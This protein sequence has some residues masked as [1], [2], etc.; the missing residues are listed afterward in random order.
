MNKKTL[1]TICFLFIIIT[2]S[3]IGYYTYKSYTDKKESSDMDTQINNFYDVEYLFNSGYILVPKTI[4][5]FSSKDGEIYIYLDANNTMYIKYTDKVEKN[6][7]ITGL[8][9]GDLTI[10]YNNIKDRYYEFVARTKDNDIYYVYTNINDSKDNKFTLIKDK[11]EK[12][13]IPAHDKKQVYINSTSKFITNYIFLGTDGELKYI[14]Y[15]IRYVFKDNLKD[16]KPYFD[17]ICASSNSIICNYLLAYITFNN[18]LVYDDEKLSDDQ[19]NIIYVNDV[20]ATFEFNSNK[21]INIKNKND[22]K[23]YNYSFI[24]YII[25]DKKDLYEFTITNKSKDL[26]KLTND[27]NKVKEYIYEKDIY[28]LTIVYEDTTT[29]V[30]ESNS[31]KEIITSTIYDKNSNNNEKVLIQP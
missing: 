15:N 11:I 24:L 22:L 29:K 12:V 10:Y 8:P 2:F 7:K 5:D 1:E 23:K 4:E 20:F 27:S 9:N 28:K 14:D 16:K 6:K 19:G 17:Y 26:K 13:Y 18:E 30:I 3:I 25:D 31:K 21:K